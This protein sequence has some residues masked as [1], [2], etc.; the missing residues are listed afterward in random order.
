MPIVSLFET[1]TFK[2]NNPYLVGQLGDGCLHIYLKCLKE[3]III[4]AVHS[5]IYALSTACV[6]TIDSLSLCRCDL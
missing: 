2:E 3:R 6:V 5:P 1:F 4:G